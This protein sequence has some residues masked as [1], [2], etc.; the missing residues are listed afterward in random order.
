MV[1]GAIIGFGK[2]AQN[3][4][5]PAFQNIEEKG[6]VKIVAVVEPDIKNCKS[7]SKKYPAIKFYNSLINLYTFEKLDFVDITS[8][9]IFHAEIIETAIKNNVNIICEKPFAINLKEARRVSE[10]LRG[11]KLVF[12]PCHQYKYAP[13]WKNFK[14]FINQSHGDSKFIFQSSVYRTEADFGL[15]VFN[16]PWRIK[17]ELSGGGILTDT[18]IHYLYL[19]NWLM[20]KP[21]KVTAKIF[22]IKHNYNVEDT[23]YLLIEY[24]TGIAEITLTWAA[25]VRANSASLNSKSGSLVYNGK[26]ELIKNS[27]IG[28]ERISIPDVSDKASYNSL[29]AALF[30]EFFENLKNKRN[31][32]KYITEAFDSISLLEKCYESASKQKTI[33]L[34]D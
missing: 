31:S 15:P 20:G 27:S 19:A 6:E 24:D 1:R 30:E 9:P 11:K 16:N 2:I 23:S 25:G 5:I 7:S 22:N 4:H 14:E 10:N 32:L 8:P 13:L 17:K 33:F 29:Y 21:K 34:N 18:G 12:M 3:S 28:E 26:N